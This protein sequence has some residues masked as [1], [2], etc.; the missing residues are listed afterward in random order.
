MTG[1]KVRWDDLKLEFRPMLE[2]AWPL[3]LANLGWMS[4]GIVDTMMVGRVSAAAIGAVSLGSV[5]FAT[6]GLFGAGVMLGL[7]ALVPQAFG[8]GRIEDCHRALLNSFYL[9]LPLTV[10]LMAIVGSCEPMLRGFGIHPAV[11]GQTLPYLRALNW[12]TWPL[13]LYFSFR[14]YLQGM[15]LVKPVLLAL[16]TANLVNAAGD[17]ILIYGHLGAPAMGAEGSG[18][19]TCISRYYM[20]LV[21]LVAILRNDRRRQTGL[22]EAPL[23][24]DLQFI[25]RL[26]HLGVPAALQIAVEIAVF[27]V[28]TMLIGKLDPVSLSGHQIAMITV[29]STYMVPL[30][31]GSAAAVRVGQALGR[32]DIVAARRSGAA[33]LALGAGFM[34]CAAVVLLLAPRTIVRAYTPDAAVI[35]AGASLLVVGAFFQVFDGF[36]VVATGALRGAGDTRTPFVCHLLLYWLFGLPLGY[37]LC[38]R[39]GW[40]AMGLWIGLCAAL[41]LIG[42][43]LFRVWFRRIHALAASA[44]CSAA[45]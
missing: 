35:E 43:V 19:A 23:R 5:L 8:A 22:K 11:L 45:I 38:F 32:R 21:L 20:A 26:M 10:A 2:L 7:D 13:I 37:F 24:P 25:G 30:G 3:V 4:M 40:G 34:G 27:A 41:I 36:Q 16:V 15:N 29:S 14:G 31:I 18:W 44:D 42:V 17:W 12:G 6:I 39:R 33:A 28:A 1:L 9:S